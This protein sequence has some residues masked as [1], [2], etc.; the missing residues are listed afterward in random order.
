[1]C[2]TGAGDQKLGE[3]LPIL[4]FLAL[5]MQRDDLRAVLASGTHFPV[6]AFAPS[7]RLKRQ[8]RLP[9]QVQDKLVSQLAS[10]FN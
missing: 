4:R 5:A 3:L 6:Q 7:T 10:F 1:M 2:L 8:R 9:L